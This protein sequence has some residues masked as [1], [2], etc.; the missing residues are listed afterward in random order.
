MDSFIGWIGGKKALRDTIISHFPEETPK[1]YIEVFGGAGWVMFRKEKASGQMEVFNDIDGNLINLYRCIKYHPEAVK[2]ELEY[3][4]SSRELFYD[5]KE[6]LNMRGMTDIQRA[7]RY[8]YLIKVSFGCKKGT[9]ATRPKRPELPLNRFEE[10]QERLSGVVIE[11]RDFEELIKLYDSCEALFY[12]DPPYHTTEKYY[13]G[14]DGNFFNTED[15]IRLKDCLDNI[16][17]KFILSYNDDEFIRDM[18]KEYN[19]SGVERNNLLMSGGN[20]KKFK[21]LIIKNF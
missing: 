20:S 5:F 9:F 15:H 19:I 14:A 3:I 1:R 2:K 13:K 17:G 16:K 6:Q 8:F 10:I 21:E 11:N 12:L 4:I 18:Y 7:A